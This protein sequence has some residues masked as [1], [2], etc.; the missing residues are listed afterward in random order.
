MTSFVKRGVV[1]FLFAAT[2]L[3]GVL[4]GEWVTERRYKK[5]I[6]DFFGSNGEST[7]V[8]LN[9]YATFGPPDYIRFRISELTA[10]SSKQVQI[11]AMIALSRYA[12]KEAMSTISKQLESEDPD[13]A[14]VARRSVGRIEGRIQSQESP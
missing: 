1:V 13:V 6:T 3:T 8:Y 11:A 2:F 12:D 14:E 10:V 7:I 5:L 4:F 9:S